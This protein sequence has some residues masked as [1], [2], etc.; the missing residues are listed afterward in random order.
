MSAKILEA[1]N[2]AAPM[3]EGRDQ[4]SIKIDPLLRSRIE[5]AARREQRT[6]AGQIRFLVERALEAQPAQGEAA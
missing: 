1:L 4:L 5:E 3:K 2:M 6:L